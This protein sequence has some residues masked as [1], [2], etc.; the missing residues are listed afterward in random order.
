[1]YNSIYVPAKTKRR[2]PHA[3][4]HVV[5]VASGRAGSPRVENGTKK[6][7]QRERQQKERRVAELHVIENKLVTVN[8]DSSSDGFSPGLSPA[9]SCQW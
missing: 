6:V 2:E 8:L 4:D 9:L 5:Q 3:Q 1:M 7:G